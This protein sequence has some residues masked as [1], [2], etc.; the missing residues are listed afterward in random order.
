MVRLTIDG[1]QIMVDG[2]LKV[3]DAAK[4]L[5][6]HIPTFCDHPRLSELGACRMCLVE[7]E[8]MGKLQT[9]CT[10]AV[11]D[12][13]VV[14]TD[15]PRVEHARKMMLE[16]L[17][18]NHPL[19]CTVCDASG[20]CTLQDFA[21]KYGSAETRFRGEKRVLRDH[22]ISPLIDRNL[23]RCIQCK[24]CVRI[25]DEIQGV[26]ALGMSYRGAA[27]VVGPFM[28]KD[29]DCE[30]C[31]HCIWSCPVGAI[32]SRAMKQKVRTWEL[33]KAE[34]IC[35]FC[36]CGC[37]L[38]YN[39]RNNIVH[40]VTHAE[41]RGVNQGSLCSKGYFGYDII[42]HPD[43]ITSPLVRDPEGSLRTATWD[44]ALDTVAGRLS[45]ILE[46]SGGESI[47]GIATDRLTNEEL[48][49]FQKLFRVG[50][51]SNNIDIPS[52]VWSRA[53]LPVLEERLGVFAATNS[54]D[55]LNYVNA[56]LLIG[57]DITVA[58]PIAG[59]KVKHAI[60]RGGLVTE[61]TPKGTALSR[62]AKRSLVVS[63]GKELAFV[64]GLIKVVL[65][66]GLY[67]EK[68]VGGHKRFSNL[69]FSVK[70]RDLKTI[71]RDLDL[72]VD[73]IA[74]TAREFAS[75]QKASVVFGE[76]AALQ[77]GG[78]DLINALIDLMILTGKLGQEGCGL[79]PVITNTNFQGAVDMGVDPGRL[80]GHVPADSPSVRKHLEKIWKA[81]LPK[82]KGMNALEMIQAASDGSLKAL[83][84]VGVNPVAS[85]PGGSGVTE[86]LEKLD[87]L[88]VQELFLTETALRADVVLPAVSTAEK[89]GTLTSME[90]RI[91]RTQRAI[92][93]VGHSMPDWRIFSQLGT[94]CGKEVMKYVNAAE[95][96]EEI[97][98]VVPYYSGVSHRILA[99]NGLQ[100]PFSKEDA[101]EI[102]HEGYLGTRHLLG[103][104]LP[105]DKQRFAAVENW[106]TISPDADFPMTLVLGDLLFHSGTF[107]RYSESLN[108]LASEATLF[109]NPQTGIGLD[110]PEGSAVRAISAQGEFSVR[111]AYAEE[112]APGVLFI[113]R[114]FANAPAGTLM[115]STREGGTETAVV[116]V[117][118][119]KA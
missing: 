37:T 108:K 104:G 24:R 65:E 62:L 56:L 63:L 76:T 18:I 50:F 67:D 75:A 74:D 94:A 88:V 33:E 41:G 46:E 92:E 98:E 35:P 60:Q 25:C 23:N 22:I 45:Q 15:T 78:Q 40:R 17:L 14:L 3:L 114:H 39:T 19:E 11:A 97:A 118:V 21:F 7:V 36:S 84:L 1:S 38:L 113:P 51:A 29:L 69:E 26:T 116:R 64:K 48:F 43:R 53:V 110:V 47:G 115:V 109:M 6:I 30:Y 10:L 103:D 71:A 105:S 106:E 73:D 13:M 9:A 12:G 112:L 89:N 32:T 101:R 82:A 87:F 49:L 34:A 2:N 107:T 68:A 80:P 85:F 79:Y 77:P 72:T 93:G 90:R 16:F 57:C 54:M 66:E 83:Y 95:V 8:G 44:E 20:E 100:W 31:S 5:G 70:G 102:Y 61:I 81:K 27:T 4:K 59:L 119:V 42:N 58:S 96:L 117:R 99:D 52:G 111:V 28:D 55:E 86:A 91:Q